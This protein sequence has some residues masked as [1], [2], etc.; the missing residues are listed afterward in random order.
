LFGKGRIDPLAEPGLG[1]APAQALLKQDLVDAAALN[2]DALRLMQVDRQPVERPGR[3]RQPKRLRLGQRTGDHGGSLLSRI[4]RRTARTVPVLERFHSF[5]IE[6]ADA[7]AY[8]L[9]IKA[10]PGC[11]RRCTLATTGAPDDVGALHT[12]D[13]SRVGVSQALDGRELFSG[14][15]P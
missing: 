13:R 3:E 14:Q 7:L 5:S 8:G 2:G 10:N 1:L 11:N 12:L 6:A 4:G 9:T 15:I